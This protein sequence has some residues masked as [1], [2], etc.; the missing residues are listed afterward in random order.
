MKFVYKKPGSL[1]EALE[2]KARYRERGV[3]IAGGT[4]LLIDLK[5]GL[6]QPEVIIDISSLDE[7]R[8]IRKDDD[9]IRIGAVTTISSIQKSPIVQSSAPILLKAC[10][11]FAN[12]LIKNVATIGGNLVNASPAADM[13]PP[14]LVLEASVVLKSLDGE[15]VLDL[16]KFFLGVKSTGQRSDEL[17]TE[18]RFKSAEGLNCEFVKLG[19]RRG[20]SISIVSLALMFN[21]TDGV[22]SDGPRIA[23]G[24]VAP[25]PFRAR[26]AEDVLH[27]VEPSLENLKR[28]GVA[29]KREVSPITDIRGSAGYRKEVS[30][31]L[32]LMAFQNL[33]YAC[34]NP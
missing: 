16:E 33:G 26:G 14:L 5:S 27:G 25:V 20:S 29:L 32:L 13:A 11:Q 12:P 21:L 10:K 24:A 22:I 19:Q 6:L 30:A 3:F 1:A 23:L 15:R 8:Y 7:I 18:I 17:L 31:S 4:D 9:H 28:A 34:N 2:L